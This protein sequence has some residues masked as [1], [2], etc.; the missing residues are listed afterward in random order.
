VEEEKSFVNSRS[1]NAR[2]GGSV[3][4]FPSSERFGLNLPLFL[5]PFRQAENKGD[6]NRQGA[7]V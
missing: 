7:G 3:V 1:S 6:M 4:N 2:P 5:I